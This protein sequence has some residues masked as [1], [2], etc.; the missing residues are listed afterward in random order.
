VTARAAVQ[1]RAG[2]G[3][4][5]RRVWGDSRARAVIVYGALVVACAVAAY[6][7]LFSQFAVYDDQVNVVQ[8]RYAGRG[9]SLLF[10]PGDGPR[11]LP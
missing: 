2:A 7:A 3:D 9:T 4:L 11:R 8:A 5:V 6:Y 1:P 10:V